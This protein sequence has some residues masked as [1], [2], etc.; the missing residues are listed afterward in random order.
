MEPTV[1]SLEEQPEQQRGPEAEEAS[2][3]D[4]RPHDPAALQGCSRPVLIGCGVTV[5]VGALLFLLVIVKARDLFVWAFETNARQILANLPPD[6][7]AEDEERLR[8]A[9]DA[10]SA[11]VL[12][13]RIDLDGLQD[14][15]GALALAG[16]KSVTRDEVLEAVEALER[17]AGTPAPETGARLER[18]P[19]AARAPAGST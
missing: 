11:A 7:T 16:R 19:P 1:G 3:F 15:Q 12:E 9:F 5:L 4:T 2:P 17:V 13:G 10:A 14:L 18:G 8:R 6:V